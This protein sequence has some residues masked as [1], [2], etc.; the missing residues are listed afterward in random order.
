MRVVQV[1]YYFLYFL[2]FSI[3]LW[4]KS[5]LTPVCTAFFYNFPL[6]DES[7]EEE[8]AKPMTKEEED[9]DLLCSWMEVGGHPPHPE[10]EAKGL[11]AEIDAFPCFFPFH[12]PPFISYL[13][14]ILPSQS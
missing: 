6:S 13:L 2:F 10:E 1:A 14:L 12:L 8:R 11:L 5:I 9:V 4:Y 7:E 3:T